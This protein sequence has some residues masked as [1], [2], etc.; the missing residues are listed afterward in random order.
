MVKLVEAVKLGKKEKVLELYKELVLKAF[1][2]TI[3]I[4]FIVIW[5]AKEIIIFFFTVEYADATPLF[6]IYLISFIVGI[7]GSG[8]VLRA[9]GKTKLTFKAYAYSGILVVPLSF[10]LI[11][12]FGMRGAIS[13][14]MLGALLPKIIIL[15]MEIKII[16]C[17]MV[18]YFPWKDMIKIT[19][20]S[21]VALVPVVAI[22]VIFKSHMFAIFITSI[23][24]LLLVISFEIKYGLFIIDKAFILSK[25]N[26]FKNK[27][28]DTKIR[29]IC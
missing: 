25:I 17:R 12:K 13:T 14:A 6:Q 28:D 23:F 8:V 21:I 27:M 29:P 11:S 7:F 1:S 9:T 5:H 18:E 15:Y 2:Y 20:I 19:A 3:P 16:G 26:L 10:L 22:D 4:I 24:Y